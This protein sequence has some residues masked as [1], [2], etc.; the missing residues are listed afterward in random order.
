VPTG[1]PAQP[2]CFRFGLSNKRAARRALDEILAWNFDRI[3]VG[4]GKI[5]ET[6]GREA[7][8]QGYVWLRPLDR[9]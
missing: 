9:R 2:P 7:L 8:A 6:G 4:H 1:S 5:V 3:I